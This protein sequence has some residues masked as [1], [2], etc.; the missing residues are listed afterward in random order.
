MKKAG[1]HIS[2]EATAVQGPRGL[3]IKEFKFK[4]T[5]S[6]GDNVYQVILENNTV[7]GELTA[8]KGDKGLKGDTGDNG[9]GIIDIKA[10]EKVDKTNNWE[11][12]YT[13]GKK[14]YI[15]VQDG[16]SAFE[17]AVDNGFTWE[18]TGEGE[19]P[20]DYGVKKWLESLIGKG[21]EFEWR[22]TELGVR[23]EGETEYKYVNLKGQTGEAGRD[24]INGKN[25]E[26]TWRG[27]E[28]GVRVQG[29]SAYQY[30]NLKGAKGDP[31]TN[32]KN[33]TDGVG[34]KTVTFKGTDSKG[35]NVYIITLT[36]GS[37]YEFTAPKG[38]D[39]ASLLDKNMKSAVINCGNYSKIATVYMPQ[40]SSSAIINL[41]TVSGYNANADQ[42]TPLTITLRS[43]NDFG[44]SKDIGMSVTSLNFGEYPAEA[45]F[46]KNGDYYDIYIKGGQYAQNVIAYG[47]C[48]TG[49]IEFKG[50]IF[51]KFPDNIVSNENSPTKVKI[52]I[53]YTRSEIDTKFK[54]YPVPVGG[55]LMMC[56]TSNPAEIYTGTTW[57]KIESKFLLGSGSNYSLGSTGGASTVKLTI[58]H[59]PAHTHNAITAS[60]VHTQP[61]HYHGQGS[62]SEVQ[63]GK[64]F[65]V[66]AAHWR[67][68]N[69]SSYWITS[70]AG[71]ETTGSASPIT[72]IESTGKGTP[73]SI[74]PPYLAVNIWKR[75]T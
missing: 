71:G 21:L 34:I 43:G 32:G 57:E 26:F 72:T 62:T 42:A 61:E 8:K 13:N 46:V 23:V 28:L 63:S 49:G 74:I 75:L 66:N 30:V 22:G 54:N 24:G 10:V 53:I 50:E 36:N 55:I 15:S 68:P 11:I 56:N 60:H 70:S 6:N 20:L 38:S 37:T 3:S 59:L 18:W 2:A 67:N 47:V 33:G 5:L 12:S 39:G 14:D 64:Y 41:A 65:A 69:P 58:E 35:G 48:S 19:E 1:L 31:G 17:V 51:D 9:N 4:E 52:N 73:F 16:D 7:I 44:N 45:G 29:Q 25:L 40:S 27:T